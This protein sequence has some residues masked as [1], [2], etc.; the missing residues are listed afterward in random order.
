[1]SAPQLTL[2]LAESGL[3]WMKLVGVME[4][5]GLSYNEVILDFAKEEQKTEE[6]RKLNPNGRIPT[7]VDHS[8]NDE[9]IWESNA[10]LKYI[11][12][13]YDTEKRLLVTDEK[14]KADLDTWL[15]YQ[16][17]HQGP[18]FGNCQWF[19]FYHTERLPSAIIRF[20]GEIKR[21][22]GVLNDVLSK[23][24]WLVGGKYTIADL[25]FV[26]YNDYA[27]HHLL[28]TDF[29]V[30]KEFPHLAAWHARIMSRPAVQY[31]FKHMA[32][33][34]VG[35]ERQH[36]TGVTHSTF[37]RNATGV[38]RRGIAAQ[39]AKNELFQTA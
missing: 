26:K 21:I 32:E 18:T 20:Q 22:F 3:N 34:D 19:M 38:A 2:Y 37:A 11:A 15:F 27:I 16:A 30:E 12:E 35:R 6:Y 33:M 9:V 29:N 4:E 23:K 25:A 14:D 39:A 5:L 24:E 28:P 8:N 17:S 36:V 1:M 10:I 13:R 31:T 7:L